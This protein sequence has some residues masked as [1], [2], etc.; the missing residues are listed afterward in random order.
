MNTNHFQEFTPAT[1]QQFIDVLLGNIVTTSLPEIAGMLQLSGRLVDKG[2]VSG[3]TNFNAKIADDGGAQIKFDI[4]SSLLLSRGIEIGHQ[5]VIVGR[6]S[7]RSSYLGIEAKVSASDIKP[8][9]GQQISD[10]SITQSGAMTI[11]RLKTARLA[12]SNFPEKEV[13]ELDLIQSNSLAAQVVNDAMIELNKVSDRVRVNH[14][15][16]NMLDPVALTCAIKESHSDVLVVI[17]GGGP[18]SDFELFNDARVV[19]ALAN[20]DAYRVVGLGHSGNSTLLDVIADFSAPTPSYAGTF[21][22]EQIERQDR[23]LADTARDLKFYKERV[24]TA[25]KE[26]DVALANAKTS[27][28]LLAKSQTGVPVSWFAAASITA[29]ICGVLY[30]LK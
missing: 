28:D 27:S 20:Q 18:E 14:V 17:R 24:A 7:V 6:L 19:E 26:R 2:K 10:Q 23:R 22:R 15:R 29:I 25:E 1:L 5:V 30:Y 12:R 3:K 21:V 11:E 8:G 4:P 16:I 9:E 13:L